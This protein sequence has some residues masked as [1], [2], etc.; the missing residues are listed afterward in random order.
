MRNAIHFTVSQE[1][2]VRTATACCSSLYLTAHQRQGISR[3]LR[4]RRGRSNVAHPTQRRPTPTRAGCVHLY[5]LHRSRSEISTPGITRD[6]NIDK[7]QLLIL[8]FQ[9]ST[10]LDSEH[11]TVHWTGR[12]SVN[13]DTMHSISPIEFSDEKLFLNVL[14]SRKFNPKK[15]KSSVTT[16]PD[17]TISAFEH[18][19]FT[20]PL[21]P[22]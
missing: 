7:T 17:W 2:L 8:G 22:S 4:P 11:R 10:L 5:V 20:A 6:N 12:C 18:N 3:G 16:L 15:G 14:R 9:L 21:S 1:S 19:R 13:I